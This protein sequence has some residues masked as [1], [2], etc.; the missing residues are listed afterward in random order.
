MLSQTP[1]IDSWFKKQ[2][3][4]KRGT[5]AFGRGLGANVFTFGT[6][7]EGTILLLALSSNEQSV[8]VRRLVEVAVTVAVQE[9]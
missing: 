3:A 4:G 2:T 7:G 8:I 5:Q 6:D 1:V 9:P